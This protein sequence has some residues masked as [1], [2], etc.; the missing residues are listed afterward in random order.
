MNVTERINRILFIMSFVAQNQGVLL[1]E[2]GRQVDMNPEELTKEL[3]FMLLI[4]KPPFRPDDYV[5]IY[6]EDNRVYI[7]F[8]QM[9]NRPLRLTRGEA[10][11][12]L[13]SLQL[14]DPEVDPEAVASLKNKI[15]QLITSSIDPALRTE[16]RIL[17]DRPA[18]PVSAHF[19]RLR[20][21]IE[22]R[23]K[24]EIEYYS[25]GQDQTSKRTVRPYFLTKSLDYWYLTGYCELRQ[26]LR[27]FKFE[28]MLG[29]KVLPNSF[30]APQDS[31]IDGFKR[32]FLRSMGR[33]HIEIQF[34]ASVAPWVREQYGS[35]VREEPEGRVTLSLFSET[36]EYPS[37]LVLSFAPFARPL[38][39]PELIEKVAEDARRI[40]NIYSSE[41]ASSSRES[42]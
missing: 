10:M 16:D 11:A 2:L 14:L 20:R 6:V 41:N 40:C 42:D 19:E 18:R 22:R 25:L 36:L 15:G 5:D 24:V 4:G 29:V 23:R 27:T 33:R 31:V 8:D 28:R 37:R 39:P 17:L 9:L 7:E 26:D 13:M 32:E 34:D 35:S 21:A 30:P 38:S 12:L 3:E 1:E